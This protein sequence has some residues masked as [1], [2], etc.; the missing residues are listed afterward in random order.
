MSIHLRKKAGSKSTERT[1]SQRAIVELRRTRDLTQQGLATYM[2]CNT[3]TVGRWEAIRPPRGLSLAEL[4][5]VARDFDRP[6]LAEIFD[7][8][9]EREFRVV[10]GGLGTHALSLG[11]TTSTPLEFALKNLYECA[12]GDSSRR[13]AA[14][15]AYRRLIKTMVSAHAL[16][17]REAVRGRLVKPD[18]PEFLRQLQSLQIELEAMQDQ[19]ESRQ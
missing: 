19:E 4:A 8:E 17:V 5:K 13:S 1:E 2:R 15:R 6:D 7:R 3:A 11:I 16:L 14:Y 18:Q 12:R 10:G 9:L